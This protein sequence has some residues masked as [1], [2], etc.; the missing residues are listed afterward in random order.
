MQEIDGEA[1]YN[2]SAGHIEDS[3]P[4]ETALENTV[5]PVDEAIWLDPKCKSTLHIFGFWIFGGLAIYKES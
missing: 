1:L 2:T 5:V 3:T 4:G